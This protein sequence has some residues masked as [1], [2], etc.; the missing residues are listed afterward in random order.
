MIAITSGGVRMAGA[1]SEA[2]WKATLVTG[3]RA[4]AEDEG[5]EDE[6]NLDRKGR[7]PA[8]AEPARRRRPGPPVE[9]RQIVYASRSCPAVTVRMAALKPLTSFEFDPPA[10]IGNK[11]GATGDGREGFD[12]WIRVGDAEL[13]RS[14]ESQNSTPGS[15]FAGTMR[16]LKACASGK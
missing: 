6:R 3:P 14:A 11:D 16:A 12:L 15:W 4:E 13:N 9:R 10:L 1:A 8:K 2:D 7:A 5:E